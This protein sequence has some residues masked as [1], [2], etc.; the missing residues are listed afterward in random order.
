MKTI[1]Q[2]REDIKQLM[3]AANQMDAKAT[4]ENR[5]LT[6][7][8]VKLKNEILD[9]VEELT[10]TVAVMERQERI[11]ELLEK[12]ISTPA[13]D[14]KPAD[15]KTSGVEVRDKDKFKSFGE[16]MAAVMN[17]GIPG[18]SVDPRLLNIRGAATGLSETV[19]SD[20]GFVIQED[21]V[22]ELLEDVFTTG[23]LAQKCRRIQISAKSNAV[24][25]PGV[26]ETSRAAG[27]RYGGVRAYWADEAEEK[28]KSKPKFRKIELQL[29]KLIGLVY[30][31]DEL[32]DD[33]SAL[34]AYVK[35]AFAGEFGFQIDDAIIRGTGAGMPLGIL[36]AGCLVTQNKETGQAA[37]TVVTENIVKMYSR[38]FASS[39][40]SAVWLVNQNVEPHLFTMSLPVGTGGA[41]T[42][43]PPGGL[44]GL[45]YGTLLGRP[46]LA[47]EQCSSIG[48]VGD[49]IFAD[50][51]NGYVLAEKG[52]MSSDV[53]IHV[54][55]VYDE[56]CFRFVLRI[57]GQPVRASALTPYKGGA[58]YTQ[59]HFIA[60]QAR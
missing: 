28:T 59:S 27:S 22:S 21:F 26:D 56:T 52:G 19:P 43:M 39:R 4:A 34:G 33:A 3:E 7:A 32:M 29:K 12:P 40:G 14:P 47:I 58:S 57:D 51:A 8:E 16:Q 38:L 44:S 46:V 48:D 53:S 13:S 20:G 25:I 49:I 31:T 45:P 17:A 35:T 10:G 54:R 23:V 5:D 30:L 41:P 42:Y 50:F 15:Q 24:K 36:N 2:Y 11:G 18:R 55:F 6:E 60:L 37:D 9:Q 1:S